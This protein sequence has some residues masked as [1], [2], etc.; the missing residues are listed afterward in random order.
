MK[1]VFSLLLALLMVLSLAACGGNTPA[2][3][4]GSEDSGSDKFKIAIVTGTVSQS[5]DD[6]RGAEAI[7]AK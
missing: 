5:E 3:P 2:E 4:S 1:K 6:R 7:Q